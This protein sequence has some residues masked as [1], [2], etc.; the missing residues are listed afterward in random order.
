MNLLPILAVLL[1]GCAFIAGPCSIEA[2]AAICEAGGNMIIFPPPKV[3]PRPAPS[4]GSGIVRPP[5]RPT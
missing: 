4:D 3:L 1:A 2:G 5:A